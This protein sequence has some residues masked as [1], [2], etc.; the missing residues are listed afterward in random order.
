M[1]SPTISTVAPTTLTIGGQVTITGSGFGASQGNGYLVVGSLGTR[2]S[3]TSWSD[4]QIVASVAAG[5]TAP[6][7]LYIS[8]NG[9]YSNSIPITMIPATIA[10]VS[11]TTLSTGTQITVAG[12]GFG[13]TKGSGHLYV[14][15]QATQPTIISWSD[16]QIVATVVAG[17]QPGSVWVQQN[18]ITSNSLPITIT[19]PNISSVSPPN[20]LAGTQVT[21]TGTG[22]GAT[23]GT[24]GRV[25]LGNAWASVVSWS[26][27]QIVA[28]VASGAGSGIALVQNLYLNSNTLPFGVSALNLSAISPSNGAVGTQ[29]TITGSGFGASQGSS[30]VLIGTAYASVVTWSSTQIVATVATG[31]GR[32][33]VQVYQG[34]YWSSALNFVI[35]PNI[36][37]LSSTSGPVGASVTLTG[38]SGLSHSN[39][40]N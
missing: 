31:A 32:G 5:T 23:Q 34:G 12:S 37:S 2:A 28:T 9:V 14:G 22:F 15:A 40:S 25:E 36:S 16:S 7:G 20:G 35:N 29:V 24:Y 10:T 33:T 30:K 11:P 17:T 38:S 1:T 6:G 39:P 3:I 21:I 18:G 19:P 13:A 27:T 8:Q 26:D 4:S